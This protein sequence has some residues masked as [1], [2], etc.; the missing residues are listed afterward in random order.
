M[1][2]PSALGTSSKCVVQQFP[3]EGRNDTRACKYY[4]GTNRRCEGTCYS[5]TKTGTQNTDNCKICTDTLNFFA[6]CSQEATG[7]QITVMRRNGTCKV[8]S[9]Y[10]DKC[11][12]DNLG[13]EVPST[14]L[15]Y[16]ASGTGCNTQS[17]DW[18]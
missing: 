5:F 9:R 10:N 2:I 11:V 18:N 7:T 17:G 12:C 15:C 13:D 1:P 16:N 6:E 8:A 4:G 3:P 14:V